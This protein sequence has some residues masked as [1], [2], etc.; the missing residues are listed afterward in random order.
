M[1]CKCGTQVVEIEAT[2]FSFAGS[3]LKTVSLFLR[4]RCLLWIVAP[5]CAVRR[6]FGRSVIEGCGLG[7]F[8]DFE[9]REVDRS[10]GAVFGKVWK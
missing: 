4:F 3:R 1:C 5:D 6:L 7:L 8:R 2:Q 9:N 10:V